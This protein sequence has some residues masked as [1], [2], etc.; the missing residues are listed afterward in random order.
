MVVRTKA[1]LDLEAGGY[2]TKAAMTSKKR[3]LT[4]AITNSG[5]GGMVDRIKIEE[6]KN[7]INILNAEN[8]S[9]QITNKFCLSDIEIAI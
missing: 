7:L 6:T 2:T 5:V 9:D 3:P 1:V 4:Y 8:L